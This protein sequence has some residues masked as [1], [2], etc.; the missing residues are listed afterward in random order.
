MKSIL[1]ERE[2]KER[3]KHVKFKQP[4]P[5]SVFCGSKLDASCCQ[6]M[7]AS[8][9]NQYQPQCFMDPNLMRLVVKQCMSNY[10][11]LR[12]Q[13]QPW[14]FMDPNNACQSLCN[15]YQ[16]QCFMDPNNACQSL[17]PSTSL[18]VSWIQTMHVKVCHPVPASVFHGSKQHMSKFTTQYQPRCFV[19]PNNACQSLRNQ[20]QPQ[21]FVDPNN[22]CQSLPPSTSLGVSWIQTTHVK[23]YATSTSLGAL[24]IQ[25]M[26]VK[27]YH[28]VPASV[29]RGSSNAKFMQP[30]FRGTCHAPSPSLKVRVFPQLALVVMVRVC[31][32]VGSP[33]ATPCCSVSHLQISPHLRWGCGHF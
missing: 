7:H 22:A 5:A 17:P 9:R 32:V 14:C 27:V 6:T 31:K 10:A 15:Q 2:T 8:L 12:N 3:M 16:P 11:S 26:H 18:G 30:V 21:C 23:V 20:Y 25:T 24:W 28:P 13:Y 4:V 19:D 29:L 33:K 1:A